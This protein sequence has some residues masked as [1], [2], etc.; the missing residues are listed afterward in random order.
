MIY[1]IVF[2]RPAEKSFQR[3]PTEVQEILASRISAL[4][5]APHPHDSRKLEGTQ[6]CYRLRQGDYRVVYTVIDDC[7]LV[8]VLRV[9]HRRDVYRGIANLGRTARKRNKPRG[10]A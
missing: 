6:D 8:L 9:G 10:T 3:L 7:V 1:R 5:D 4:S 2:D